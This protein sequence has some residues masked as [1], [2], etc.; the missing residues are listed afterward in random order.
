VE[1][2][3]TELQNDLPKKS[4][5]PYEQSAQP[6]RS[7]LLVM[8]NGTMLKYLTMKLPEVKTKLKQTKDDGQKN[9]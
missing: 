4:M 9:L 7:T 6:E 2:Q 5:S 3:F 8:E 1:L